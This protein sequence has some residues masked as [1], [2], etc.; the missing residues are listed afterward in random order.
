MA[1]YGLE[2]INTKG[3]V[4]ASAGTGANYTLRAAGTITNAQFTSTGGRA[5][6]SSCSIP[7]GGFNCPIVFVKPMNADARIGVLLED[8][9]EFSG[10]AKTS[11]VARFYKWWNKNVGTIQ[12]YVFDKWV[13]PERAQGYGMQMWDANGTLTFDSSWNFLRIRSVRWLDPGFPNHAANKNGANWTD[14]GAMGAGNL[15]ISMPFPRGFIIP[16][17]VFGTYCIECMHLAG[18]GNNA[19]ISVIPKGEYLDMIGNLNGWAHPKGKSEVLIADVNGIP[20]NYNP[21]VVNKP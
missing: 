6:V 5:G 15:A 17:G 14:I 8:A 20:T 10:S 11:R 1:D 4:V 7:L 2:L 18:S 12:Y 9:S 21:L 19:Y 3:H 16:T 13:P